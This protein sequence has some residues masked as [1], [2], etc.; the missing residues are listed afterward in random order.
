MALLQ[1]EHILWDKA[2]A[3]VL[4]F[5]HIPN[6]SRHDIPISDRFTGVIQAESTITENEYVSEGQHM[7]QMLQ[8][9]RGITLRRRKDGSF[10]LDIARYFSRMTVKNGHGG[11]RVISSLGTIDPV[12]RFT[13]SYQQSPCLQRGGV[14]KGLKLANTIGNGRIYNS[15]LVGNIRVLISFTNPYI[16]YE[17]RVINSSNSM[18]AFSKLKL[19]SPN[20]IY[21]ISDYYASNPIKYFKHDSVMKSNVARVQRGLLPNGDLWALG[22]ST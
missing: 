16:A 14:L 1:L 19:F 21:E 17:F 15:E 11:T 13:E 4:N 22:F 10:D 6:L 18:S 5:K 9:S 2:P 3:V 20:T 12:R 7:R 8:S